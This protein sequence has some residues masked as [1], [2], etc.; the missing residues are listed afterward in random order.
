MTRPLIQINDE[1]REMTEEE[2]EALLATGWTWESSE[3]SEPLATEEPVATDEPVVTDEPIFS[4]R[5]F[6]P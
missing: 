1:I 3:P 4:D 5:P 6:W 2:Y